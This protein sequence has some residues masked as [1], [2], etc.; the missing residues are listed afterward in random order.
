MTA[1]NYSTIRCDVAAN[2]SLPT[3]S[4]GTYSGQENGEVFDLI[5]TC[6][7]SGCCLVTARSFADKALVKDVIQTCLWD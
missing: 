2:P 4:Y 1:S 6:Y 3:V 7:F 5:Y